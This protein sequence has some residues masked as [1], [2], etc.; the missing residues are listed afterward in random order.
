[1]RLGEPLAD[2]AA[3]NVHLISELAKNKGISVLLSGAGGDDLSQVIV[4][5]RP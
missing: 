4:G 5:I 1:M 2:L 3:I